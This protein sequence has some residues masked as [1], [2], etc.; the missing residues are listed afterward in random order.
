M[1]DQ[2]PLEQL[3]EMTAKIP[4]YNPYFAY[5]NRIMH[6]ECKKGSATATGVYSEEHISI[7]KTTMEAGTELPMHEH[8]E[9]EHIHV[10]SGTLIIHYASDSS[11]TSVK[12]NKYES[13]TI[14]PH[15]PHYTYCA[16][17]VTLIAI[18]IPYSKHFP[19]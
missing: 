15:T 17:K 4:P 16:E 10:M 18:V 7:A 19:T 14:P 13:I 11:R 8:P 9:I 6:L 3:R 12:L 1:T 5:E 2:T